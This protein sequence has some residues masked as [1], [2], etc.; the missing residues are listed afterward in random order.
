M[1]RRA[2]PPH[3]LLFFEGAEEEDVVAALPPSRLL[4][5][6]IL[7]THSGSALGIMTFVRLTCGALG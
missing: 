2:G 4:V 5:H 1:G 7:A 6:A 3:R